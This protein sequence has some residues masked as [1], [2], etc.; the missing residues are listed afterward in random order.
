MEEQ[1]MTNNMTTVGQLIKELEKLPKEMAVIYACDSEGNSYE[2][3]PYSPSII[4]LAEI[5]D[6]LEPFTAKELKE[7]KLTQA[8]VIN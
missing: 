8:V 3:L 5:A 7:R 2:F 4:E 6:V 1:K